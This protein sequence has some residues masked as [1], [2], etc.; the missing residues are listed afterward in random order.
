MQMHAKHLGV[1]GLMILSMSRMF[2]PMNLPLMK[3][4]WSLLI[5]LGTKKPNLT[6]LHVYFISQQVQMYIQ[7][8]ILKVYEMGF[9]QKIRSLIIETQD[10]S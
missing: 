8:L 3:S 1:N 4:V 9:S 10:F 7:Y 5:S 6:I 2:S